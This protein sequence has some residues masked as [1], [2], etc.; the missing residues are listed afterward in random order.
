MRHERIIC[1]CA[2]FGDDIHIDLLQYNTN[3]AE[4]IQLQRI[5]KSLSPCTSSHTH[6]V[7]KCLK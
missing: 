4:I 6:T 3:V 5:L 2:Y 7:E 1:D